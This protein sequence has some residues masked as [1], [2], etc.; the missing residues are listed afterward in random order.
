MYHGYAIPVSAEAH[1]TSSGNDRYGAKQNMT[2]N[3][4][5]QNKTN[6]AKENMTTIGEM[7][8]SEE[9]DASLLVI[10]IIALRH[11]NNIS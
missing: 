6:G 10:Q 8:L 2:K 9:G 5:K 7:A 11:N 3:G 4:A 1:C